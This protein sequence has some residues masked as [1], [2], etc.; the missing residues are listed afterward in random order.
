MS[1]NGLAKDEI[2]LFD[3]GPDFSP[4]YPV[5]ACTWQHSQEA[6]PIFNDFSQTASVIENFKQKSKALVSGIQDKIK[7]ILDNTPKGRLAVWGAGIHTSQ[8]L[9]ETALGGADLYCIFDNDPKKHGSLLGR[10]PIKK[11]SCDPADIKLHIDAI[12]ISS[13]ASEDVIYKQIS[14]LEKFGIKIYRLYK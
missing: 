6:L 12:L 1:V 11:F 2:T 4:F 9:S 7:L 3:N 13:E 14:Y 5:I 8:L 10:F